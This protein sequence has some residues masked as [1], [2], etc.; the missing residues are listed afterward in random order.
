MSFLAPS[1]DLLPP[2]PQHVLEL[3]VRTSQVLPPPLL[4]ALE[5]ANPLDVVC[6]L[7]LEALQLALEDR[8]HRVA[9]PVSLLAVSPAVLLQALV[10]AGVLELGLVSIFLYD[11]SWR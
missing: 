1:M 10:A 6:R 4:P 11:E 3:V 5:S 9:S 8:P 7:A 2:I